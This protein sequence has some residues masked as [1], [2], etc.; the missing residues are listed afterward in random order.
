MPPRLADETLHS[1]LCRG[2]PPRAVGE[3]MNMIEAM[4]R[5]LGVAGIAKRLGRERDDFVY[6]DA[7]HEVRTATVVRLK[8]ALCREGKS[9]QSFR[10]FTATHVRYA[11]CDVARG[12]QRRERRAGRPEVATSSADRA[13]DLERVVEALRVLAEGDNNN[14]LYARAFLRAHELGTRLERLART[15]LKG[16]L[17]ALSPELASKSDGAFDTG[18]SRFRQA[19]RARVR[20]REDA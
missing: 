2:E 6:I 20:R 9:V 8:N 14:G 11:V 3:L 17:R 5:R 15:E 19:L 7:V 4:V 13:A 12:A 1:A 18:L 10:A 16:F